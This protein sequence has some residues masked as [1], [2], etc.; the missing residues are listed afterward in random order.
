MVVNNILS[1]NGSG[2]FR[3]VPGKQ[4]ASCLVRNNLID[5]PSEQIREGNVTGAAQF[6]DAAQGDFHLLPDS[7]AIDAGADQNPLTTDADGRP[8]RQGDKTD[9]GA[10]EAKP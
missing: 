2:Q 1:H 5:G 7:P 4:P 9:I 8:R 6:A 10:Y 3:T